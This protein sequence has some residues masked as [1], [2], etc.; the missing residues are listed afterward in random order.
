MKIVSV[1]EMVEAERAAD[2]MGHSYVTMMELAGTALAQQVQ[3]RLE[4][5]SH[6]VM[7]LVGPGNNGGDG[8]VAARVLGKVG[9]L[10]SVFL[11][12]PKFLSSNSD[13]KEL[14]GLG[15][16]LIEPVGKKVPELFEQRLAQASIIVD[17]LLGTGIS[18]PVSGLIYTLLNIVKK[19]VEQDPTKFVIAADC[20]SGMNCNN[21]KISSVALH[22]DLTIAFGAAKIGHVLYPAKNYIG[23]LVIVDIGIDPIIM[24]KHNTEFA[25]VSLMC[26]LLPE[27]PIDGHKGTFGKVIVAGGSNE[28]L[29]APVLS[30]I[31]ALRSGSGLVALLVPEIV[32][33][34]MAGR[35]PEA[36]FVPVAEE[37]KLGQLAG[38]SIEAYLPNY[39][40]VLIGP[41]LSR[42][43][44]FVEA[45]LD[46]LKY[47]PIP[48]VFDADALNAFT[49]DGITL[50]SLPPD[51]VL[52]P[53]PGEM[54]RLLGISTAELATYNRVE[55]VRKM[56]AKWKCV[57]LLKGAN[58]VI[59]A[60]DG[61]IIV[62]PFANP[63]MSVAGSGD[64]LGGIIVSLLGQKLDPFEAAVL[65]GW[66]HGTAGELGR[67]KFGDRGMLASEIANNIPIVIKGLLVKES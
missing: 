21:G 44:H 8:L 28:Y 39:D 18:R 5:P 19:V 31:G 34:T 4:K 7:I 49:H 24:A 65:G 60:P 64:V 51:S 2:K 53:H 6:S 42:S 27:R 23:E 29:G 46:K 40:A 12:R 59:G 22:A 52:T 37:K 56:A 1:E 50:E 41:G 20:P 3:D 30:A 67:E 13:Y 9:V 32:R 11:A 66:L 54:A 15:V 62:L 57:L 58:T 26:Q 25:S 47:S 16:E 43:D 61:R 48:A 33:D 35:I 38:N 17:S 55:L 10:V 63:I 45:C 14:Q 36:V